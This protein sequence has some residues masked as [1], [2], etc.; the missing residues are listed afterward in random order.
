R[1]GSRKTTHVSEITGMEGDV[2]TMQDLFVLE[3]LG[4]DENGKLITRH[5]STGLRPKF[6]DNAR[7]FGV[8]QLVL[9]A[10]EEAYD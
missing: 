1:D 7:Q 10:M 4:E 9:D 6:F 2:V 8:E 5:K 3:I